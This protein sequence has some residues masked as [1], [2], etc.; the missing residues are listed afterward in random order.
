MAR[1]GVSYKHDECDLSRMRPRRRN[2]RTRA[3][4]F[5]WRPIGGGR[6]EH[7]GKMQPSTIAVATAGKLVALLYCFQL[8]AATAGTGKEEHHYLWH[9]NLTAFSVHVATYLF[10]RV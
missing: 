9:S 10:L 4:T 2:L 7:Q 6:S 8:S 5:A 3:R 1:L